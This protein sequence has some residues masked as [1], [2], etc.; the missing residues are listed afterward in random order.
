MITYLALGLSVLAVLI[1]WSAN[2]KNKD[3]K[4]RLAQANS[5]VYH[6]R[7]ELEESRQQAEQERML[8]KF[9]LLKMQGSLTVTPEMKMTEVMAIHPQAQQ[10]LAGFHIGGCSSCSVDDNQTLGEAV[11]VNGREL[12]PILASL[13]SLV[14]AS[15][16]G[17]GHVPPEQLKVPNIQLHI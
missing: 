5:R 15:A 13:N 14:A 8:L 1:A 2:R 10:V 17:N 11:A 9:E 6:V 16:N 12:E 7:R 3:M 4:E